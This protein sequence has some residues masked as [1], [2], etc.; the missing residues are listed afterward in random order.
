M[1]MGATDNSQRLRVRF[2]EPAPTDPGL[3][4]LPEDFLFSAIHS[5][6]LEKI[7]LIHRVGNLGK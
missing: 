6:F 4:D 5:L 7:S 3:L 1:E 2:F